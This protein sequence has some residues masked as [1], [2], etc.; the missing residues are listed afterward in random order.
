MQ[1]DADMSKQMFKCT[2]ESIQKTVKSKVI[3]A[4]Q[5]NRGLIF[6]FLVGAMGRRRFAFLA[7][8]VGLICFVFLVYSPERLKDFKPFITAMAPGSSSN[9]SSQTESTNVTRL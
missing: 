7:S 3:I 4:L 1:T 9:V 6:I 2:K 8:V 5:I